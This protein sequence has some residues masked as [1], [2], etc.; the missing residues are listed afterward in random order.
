MLA[1]CRSVRPPGH[2]GGELLKNVHTVRSELIVQHVTL[3]SRKPCS[4]SKDCRLQQS[5]NIREASS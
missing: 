1:D 4:L 2:E 3:T 5:K